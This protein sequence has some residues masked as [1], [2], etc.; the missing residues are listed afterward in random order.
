MNYQEINDLQYSSSY[1]NDL[2]TD[3]ELYIFVDFG[4]LVEID[5][6][7]EVVLELKDEK[8]LDSGLVTGFKQNDDIVDLY[9][10]NLSSSSAFND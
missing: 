7:E 4:Y 1:N 9:F 10:T 5:G 8:L 2:S 6:R 3:S